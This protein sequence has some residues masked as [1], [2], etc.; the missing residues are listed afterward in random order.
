MLSEIARLFIFLHQPNKHQAF[1][2]V[3][4]FH[5]SAID[6]VNVIILGFILI[7]LLIILL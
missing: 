3:F 1:A 4:N 7:I 5:I 6:N 2:Q